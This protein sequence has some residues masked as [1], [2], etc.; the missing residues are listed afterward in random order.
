M[1]LSI[2]LGCVNDD[3]EYYYF[4]PEQIYFWNKFGVKFIAVFVGSAIPDEFLKYGNQVILWDKTP[5]LNSTYVA[6][7]LRLYYPALIPVE[8]DESLVMITD[9]DMLPTNGDYYKMGL[10]HFEKDDFIYYREPYMSREIYMCYNS[11]H[12]SSWGKIFGIKT[13][14]DVAHMLRNNHPK[15]AGVIGTNE[16]TIDR[17]LL[18]TYFM[19]YGKK[20]IINRPIKRLESWNYHKHIND[21]DIDFIH[22]YDDMHMHKSFSKNEMY[23]YNARCQLNA[24]FPECSPEIISDIPKL[25][26]PTSEQR[27]F[28]TFGGPSQRYHSRVKTVCSQAISM[29][30]FTKVVGITERYLKEDTEYWNLHGEFI[31]KSRRGYGNCIWKPYI[32]KKLMNELND[33][34]LL[35]YLDCGCTVNNMGKERL[36]EYVDMIDKSPYGMISHHMLH[37]PEIKYSKKKLV[38]YIS[39]TTEMMEDGQFVAGIQMMR[40]NTHTIHLVDEWYR[41]AC[42]HEMIDDVIDTDENARFID[43]RHDQSIY[44]LLVKKYG[45][46]SIP[47]ETYFENWSM[48][49]KFPFLATR[50]I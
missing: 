37:L 42:M 13:E 19:K 16:W 5:E 33:G 41:I 46:V 25:N 10:E 24:R 48:G 11:A 38:D 39:P 32:I 30:F 34:D 49:L 8:S 26:I 29:N 21:G 20:H 6:Q 31:E 43:H 50:I 45:T 7:N 40:K 15:D 14:N 28:M 22:N 44:S 23:I 2:V 36:M 1:K 12:P 35:I 17:R 9:M 18:Y 4:I 27:L 47:D 3:P